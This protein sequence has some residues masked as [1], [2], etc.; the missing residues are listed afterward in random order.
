[1]VSIK[2]YSYQLQL[3]F[4]EVAELLGRV[5][6]SWTWT[7]RA[8]TG[9]AALDPGQQDWIQTGRA[10]PERAHLTWTSCMCSRCGSGAAR[11]GLVRLGLDPVLVSDPVHADPVPIHIGSGV[12]GLSPV[13]LVYVQ[14]SWIWTGRARPGPAPLDLDRLHSQLVRVWC[15]RSGSGAACSGPRATGR[16]PVQAGP[17]PVHI[18]SDI[19]I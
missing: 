6:C 5:R 3:Y 4:F 17:V 11:L 12:A 18:G 7:G 1:M 10:R 13:Q 2:S 8:G 14:C 15:S 9:P 16:D 19:I